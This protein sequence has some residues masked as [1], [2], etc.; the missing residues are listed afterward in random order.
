MEG[1]EGERCFKVQ[2]VC[3]EYADRRPVP[4]GQK[5]RVELGQPEKGKA[6][7][8]QCPFAPSVVL[9]EVDRVASSHP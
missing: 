8:G 6:D 4:E 7:A 9:A 2:G 1:R 3:A 5:Q